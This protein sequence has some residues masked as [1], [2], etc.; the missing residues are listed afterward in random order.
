VVKASFVP[1]ILMMTEGYFSSWLA[2][3]QQ[4]F[5]IRW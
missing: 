3:G 2:K 4:L 5:A 1:V